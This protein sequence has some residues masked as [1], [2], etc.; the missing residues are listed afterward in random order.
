VLDIALASCRVLPD[1]DPDEAP[2]LSALRAAGFSAKTLPWDDPKSDFADARATVLRAT[3]N[4]PERPADF[5]AWVDRTAACSRL[6]N[7]ADVVRW[8]HHKGYLLEL[9]R[10]GVPIVP[11]RLVERGETT[12][13]AEIARTGRAGNKWVD[14]V[15][16]PAVGG[17]SRGTLRVTEGAMAR[18][19]A[20]LRV[21][22][23]RGD[24]LV[25]PY[26]ASVEEYGERAIVWIDGELT[27][28]VRKSRRF[29]G[30]R[31]RVSASVPIAPDEAELARAAVAVA[32]E[33]AR[34]ALLYARVDVVR[35]E[36]SVPRVMELE[37][38]EPSLF[39]A[40]SEDAL[41]RYVSALA[42]RLQQ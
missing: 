6:F 5:L 9:E 19:D 26:M 17:G 38:I 13:L 22:V 30:D 36:H 12:P 20:H 1:P 29:L 23:D 25:Q 18:D 8:N 4:Y 31:E 24:A 3:W 15:V 32:A 10:R 33:A 2:L 27:H 39:F 16:K 35:D 42:A 37:V 40:Q 7:G 41:R 34:G 28:A 21:L 11:T 14:V